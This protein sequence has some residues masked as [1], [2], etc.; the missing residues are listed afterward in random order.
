VLRTEAT[1]P[2]VIATVRDLVPNR[3]LTYEESL[4]VAERQAGRL[5]ELASI[6]EPRVP[7][8]VVATLPRMQV[9]RLTPIPVSGSTH[10]AKGRWV[11]VLNAGEPQ[12]RQRYSL[13]HEFKH[14]LDHNVVR[15]LYPATAGMTSH[16]R[17]EQVCD[18]FAACLLMPRMWVKRSWG[19]GMQDIATLARHYAVSQSAMRVRLLQTGVMEASPRCLGEGWTKYTRPIRQPYYRLSSAL[20][21]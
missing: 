13:M 19:S 6:T 9:E 7:E 21:A 18:Y 11:I 15:V 4:R 1:M 5:L 8:G 3:P 14:V 16:A 12:G 20:A 10:W 17:I 2:S